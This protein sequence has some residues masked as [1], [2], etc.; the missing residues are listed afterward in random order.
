M[1]DISTKASTDTAQQHISRDSSATL[2][3]DTVLK[4]PNNYPLKVVIPLS[5]LSVSV[6]VTNTLVCMLVYKVKSM[7]NYTN[8]FVVSLAISDILTG[9]SFFIQ[10]NAELHEWSRAALNVLYAIVLFVGA[11]NL[12]AV[13]FDRYLAILYPF[14]YRKTISKVFKIM[15]P[16]IWLFS[17]LIACIP[18]TWEGDTKLLNTKIYI[19]F[20]LTICIALPYILIV[21][22]NYKIFRLVRQCVRRER[23]LSISS[24]NAKADMK[25]NGVRKVSSE[26]KVARVFAIASLMFVLSYFP[27]LFYTAAAVAGHADIVPLLLLEFSPFCVVFGSLVNPIL[28][29]FM[30]PD[31]RRALKKILTGQRAYLNARRSQRSSM[32]SIGDTNTTPFVPSKAKKKIYRM[33]DNDFCEDHDPFESKV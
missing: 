15:V 26:A 32:P 3:F 21:Y 14:C 23:E 10:Y 22:A 7:R 20:V 2:V 30:K 4:M 18:L 29:S 27:S 11:A 19:C 13:T 8:G 17:I 16:A 28:Y 33:E 9:V 1:P 12:C 31:F 5:I 6:I 25:N 24:N